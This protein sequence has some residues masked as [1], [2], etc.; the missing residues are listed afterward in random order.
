MRIWFVP[1]NRS[2]E[3]QDL[4]SIASELR[5]LGHRVIIIPEARTRE[6]DPGEKAE[7][8]HVWPAD[9]KEQSRFVNAIESSGC[10][11]AHLVARPEPELLRRA[12][13]AT[14]IYDEWEHLIPPRLPR[15][16]LWPGANQDVFYPR[17]KDGELFARLRIPLNATVLC[18]VADVKTR[19]LRSVRSLYVAVAVLNREGVPTTLVRIGRGEDAFLSGNGQWARKYSVEL[20]PVSEEELPR[21]L[22]LADILVEPGRRAEIDEIT[23][24]NSL[25]RL[26]AMGRP[27]ILP[28]IGADMFIE[29]EV[30]GLVLPEVDALSIVD[31]VK[32]LRMDAAL[33]QRLGQGALELNR[34]C[35]APGAIASRLDSFYRRVLDESSSGGQSEPETV[36]G[37][38]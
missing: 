26:L 25:P 24:A 38:N 32:R 14:T 10:L 5:K 8:V 27:I 1:S 17:P 4:A 35:F 28:R 23:M 16:L 18:C 19:N 31:C 34:K 11:V 7:I 21:I 2:Q 29:H 3:Q 37:N 13:A 30:H 12:V 20:G 22:S 6:T 33:A 15:L 36:A 9:A